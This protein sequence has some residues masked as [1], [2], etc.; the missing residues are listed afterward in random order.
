M[1]RKITIGGSFG[2]RGYKTDGSTI[3]GSKTVADLNSLS[4]TNFPS[5]SAMT[6]QGISLDC[7]T[8]ATKMEIRT[9]SGTKL[10]GLQTPSVTNG[11][12][13]ILIDDGVIGSGYEDG[14]SAVQT[15]TTTLAPS[16]SENRTMAYKYTLAMEGNC[17]ITGNGQTWNGSMVSG[18]DRAIYI[19]K[20]GTQI[21]A[22]G[23]SVNTNNVAT[24]DNQSVAE[25]DV[26]QYD[27][28]DVYWR[29]SSGGVQAIDCRIR[30][31]SFG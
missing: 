2:I 31:A 19:M 8:S 4:D 29:Y 10:A 14:F 26:I 24:A 27:I 13:L 21:A 23:S 6:L 3:W 16:P 28:R 15:G 12:S 17:N 20:N 30:A 9:S 25:G 1:A 7:S 18:N 11:T 22:A 5:S